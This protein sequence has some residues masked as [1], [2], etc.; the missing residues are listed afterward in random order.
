MPG[1]ESDT[2]QAEK[3]GEEMSACGFWSCLCPD[4]QILVVSASISGVENI[5]LL[6]RIRAEKSFCLALPR[7]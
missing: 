4:V 2:G 1:R 6:G 3:S 7:Y 5:W